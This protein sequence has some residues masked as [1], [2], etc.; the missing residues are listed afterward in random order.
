MQGRALPPV[1]QRSSEMMMRNVLCILVLAASHSAHA[2]SFDCAKA[3]TPQE[4]AICSSKELSAEDGQM[5]MTY[6]AALAG[7]N[8]EMTARIREDQREW[9]RGMAL[10]CKDDLS[11]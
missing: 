3:K 4:K 2:Q 9:I 7:V 1:K 6:K 11:S 8:P 10:A 5:A